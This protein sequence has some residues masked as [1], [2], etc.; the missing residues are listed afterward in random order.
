MILL[1]ASDDNCCDICGDVLDSCLSPVRT[2][3]AENRCVLVVCW[4]G[5]NRAPAITAGLLMIFG[6]LRLTE[7]AADVV[8]C[9]GRVLSNMTFQQQLVTLAC[10]LREGG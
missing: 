10:V 7:A 2:A 4:G 1:A 3:R 8:R 5:R 9:R 6:G